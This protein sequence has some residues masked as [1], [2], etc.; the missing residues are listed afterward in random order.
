MKMELLSPAGDMER[1]RAGILYGA[2][3]VYLGATEFGMRAAP[4][5]FTMEQLAVAVRFAHGH[6]VKVY[7][8]VNTLPRPDE[9]AA[10]DFLSEVGKTGID[11]LIVADLGVLT[12]VRRLLPD[13]ALCASTQTGIVNPLTA[14][15]LYELGVKKVVLARELTLSEISAIREQTPPE[16]ELEVFVHGSMCMSVSGRCVLSNYLTGR[17]ANRGECTQPCRW[18]YHLMEEKRPGIYLPVF[19]DEHGSTILS[20]KDLCMI[21]HLD[22]LA[23]V[24]IRSLKI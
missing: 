14:R 2:D 1:L 5:N 19:E 24:G 7:L 13:M 4:A 18:S 9:T 16:L 11:A 15:A 22:D 10:P 21:E 6:G 23:R 3:A 17:D 20:A 12:L 8:T